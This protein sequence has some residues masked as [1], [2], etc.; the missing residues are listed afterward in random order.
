MKILLVSDYGTREGGAEIVTL[1]LRDGLRKRGHDARLFASTAH[2]AGTNNEADVVCHGTT[3]SH[4]TLLQTANLSARRELRRVLADFQPDVVH[5][6]LFLTQLSPLIL[7]LLRNVPSVHYA[8]WLRAICPTGFKLLPDDT[9]CATPAGAV[10][11]RSGCLPLR[12]WVPIMAQMRMWRRWRSVFNRIVANSDAT[13]AMLIAEGFTDVSVIPC[14]ITLGPPPSGFTD[15]PT[16]LFCGRLTRQKGTHILLDAW[17]TVATRIPNARLLIAGDGPERKA[18]E[19]ST[20]RG[21]SFL[22]SVPHPELNELARGAWVQ[23]VPSIGFEPFGLV[24]AEGMM[25]GS[26]VVATRTGG[27]AEVV[28]HGVTGFLTEPGNREGLADSIVTLLSDRAACEE[29]GK[30]GRR[31]SEEQYGDDLY[32]D[33]FVTLYE[34]VIAVKRRD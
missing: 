13:R 23:V 17:R 30:R 16:V 1:H 8:H 2:T 10:C 24:A 4:R 18:L 31:R 26:A 19:E 14:G 7:P 6:G 3:G 25:R 9:T 20:P 12:D 28:D 15:A 11:L 29:M 21:V 27:L 22:G 34:S 32:V 33:R 5:V